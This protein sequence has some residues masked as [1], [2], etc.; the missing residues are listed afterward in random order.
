MPINE[1]ADK[2][3]SM[4]EKIDYN[5]NLLQRIDR[6]DMYDWFREENTKSDYEIIEY[7]KKQN[8]LDIRR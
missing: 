8:V 4:K 7:H 6:V 3:K 5:F 2:I 1:L